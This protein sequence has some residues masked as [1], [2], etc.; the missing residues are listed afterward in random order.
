MPVPYGRAPVRPHPVLSY[1]MCTDVARHHAQHMNAAADV[2]RQATIADLETVLEDFQWAYPNRGENRGEVVV[3]GDNLVLL[4]WALDSED[5][6]SDEL[7]PLRVATK[8][9]PGIDARVQIREL[10]HFYLTHEADEQ[11]WFSGA[12]P[13]YPEHQLVAPGTFDIKVPT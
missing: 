13:F 11:L 12:R 9:R 2:L 7:I 4:V 8:I 1:R 3:E 10:I 6:E 5:P